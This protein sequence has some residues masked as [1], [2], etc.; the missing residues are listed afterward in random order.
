[1][2]R[3]AG[4]EQPEPDVLFAKHIIKAR[5]S[6]RMLTP[7]IPSGSTLLRGQRSIRCKGRSE[8]TERVRTFVCKCV[9]YNGRPIEHFVV[10]LLEIAER[11][12]L[13]EEGV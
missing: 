13:R 1:V 12:S 4:A 11:A 10:R 8:T 9:S 2:V 7:K 3:G 6:E 5:L